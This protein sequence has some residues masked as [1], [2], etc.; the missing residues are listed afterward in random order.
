[1]HRG[2]AQVLARGPGD[3]GHWARRYAEYFDLVIISGGDGT[4]CEVINGLSGTNKPITIFPSGTENL[5]AKEMGIVPDC[6]KLIQTIKWG[7][8]VV[9]DIG[10]VNDRKFLLLSGVGFDA[11]VLLELNKF[12]TGNITHLTYFWPIWRTY[13]EYR[14]PAM[15][16]EADGEIIVENERGLMFVSNISRY[17]V[18]LRI[19]DQAKFDDGL[20]DICFYRCTHQFGLFKH[21]WHTVMRTH[22][23][24]P[25]VIY[26]QAKKIRVTSN[27]PIPFETDGDPIGNLPAEFSVIPQ[28]VRVILPP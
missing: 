2:V 19:C 13:W 11:N 3:G 28:A 8:T 14:Y 25:L 26:R 4:I 7:R 27:T 6:E 18:G 15:T 10:Q 21:A 20:L 23:Q 24:D 17:A 16:V 1:M 5:F 9:M 22:R 12:R